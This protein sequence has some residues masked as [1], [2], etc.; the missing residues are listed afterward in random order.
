MDGLTRLERLFLLCLPGTKNSY[1]LVFDAEFF[2]RS[3]LWELQKSHAGGIWMFM[4]PHNILY[5]TEYY[6]E[7]FIED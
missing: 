5:C 4:M 3:L 2:I 1:C 6:P 7:G